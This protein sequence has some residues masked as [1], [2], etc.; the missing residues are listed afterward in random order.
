M[1]IKRTST[2]MYRERENEKRISPTYH[3]GTNV[4]NAYWY[5]HRLLN[6]AQVHVV[7]LS[8]RP[9]HRYDILPSSCNRR[10]IGMTMMLMMRTT[11]DYD[12]DDHD[13]ND[14]NDPDMMVAGNDDDRGVVGMREKDVTRATINVAGKV[15]SR[16]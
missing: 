7:H 11:Y 14:D 5:H 12:C 3:A 1:F 8:S 4:E 2:D 15:G 6:F 16:A 10:G 9:H 13:D